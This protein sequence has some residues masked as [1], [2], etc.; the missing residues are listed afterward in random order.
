MRH[1]TAMDENRGCWEFTLEHG[2]GRYRYTLRPGVMSTNDVISKAVLRDAVRNVLKNGVRDAENCVLPFSR[3]QSISAL[4]HILDISSKDALA[5][6][7]NNNAT[8]C[9]AYGLSERYR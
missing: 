9:R 3:A 8:R 4:S 2:D 7:D 6:L 5:L 1:K